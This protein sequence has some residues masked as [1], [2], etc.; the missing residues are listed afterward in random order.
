MADSFDDEDPPDDRS[1]V[2]RV[3]EGLTVVAL[4]IAVVVWQSDGTLDAARRMAVAWG[5]SAP[6]TPP[7]MLS[8][9]IRTAERGSDLPGFDTTATGSV[10]APPLAVSPD[11]APPLSVPVTAPPT[12]AGWRAACNS[13]SPSFC[14]ASQSL[15][16]TRDPTLETSWTIEKGGDGLIA[17]WTTPTDVTVGRGMSLTVGQ[18]PTRTVPFAACGQHSCEVRAKL[19]PDFIAELRRQGTART[20]ILLRDGRTVTFEFS[21]VGLA[22]A[23]DRLGV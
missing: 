4:I 15:A 16:D 17:V 20:A 23:L 3:V 8:P 7:D 22:E 14:T 1:T 10:G 5:L 6:D 9:D 2:Y 18:G 21:P 13:A 12:A 11:E 19:A